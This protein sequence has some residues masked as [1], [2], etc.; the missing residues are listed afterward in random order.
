MRVQS[1]GNLV[2][3]RNVAKL[4][5]AS[6][7]LNETAQVSVSAEDTNFKRVSS[8][9]VLSQMPNVSFGRYH[10]DLSPYFNYDGPTPPE[11]EH[12][13]YYLS[14]VIERDIEQGNF[15]SAIGGKIRLA[16]ICRGQGKERDAYMLE[17]GMKA[18]YKEIPTRKDKKAAKK[19]IGEY[20]PEMAEYLDKK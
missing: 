16:T 20:N 2:L 6:Q 8:S 4:K 10:D 13:K 19:L 9:Q 14:Y 1:I 17:E 5:S 18:L 7:S 15:V 3:N 11:I 12:Q